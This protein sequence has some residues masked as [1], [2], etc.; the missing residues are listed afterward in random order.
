[1]WAWRMG[2][3][4]SE[5]PQAA[6]RDIRWWRIEAS[7]RRC[8]GVAD[9]PALHEALFCLRADLLDELHVPN[10]AD[11][12]DAVSH[13]LVWAEVEAA[14]KCLVSE[15]DVLAVQTPLGDLALDLAT[16][17]TR[18][19]PRRPSNGDIAHGESE[20]ELPRLAH[21]LHKGFR[22]PLEQTA[23]FLADA[24]YSWRKGNRTCEL[25]KQLVQ[26]LVDEA[27]FATRQLDVDG[28]HV[29]R[30]GRLRPAFEGPDVMAVYSAEAGQEAQKRAQELA[31]QHGHEWGVPF[32]PDTLGN[33][34]ESVV[35][36][37]SVRTLYVKDASAFANFIEQQ[38]VFS[39]VEH[40]GVTVIESGVP[41]RYGFTDPDQERVL[42]DGTRL[43]AA[44]RAHDR[45]TVIESGRSLEYAQEL[46]LRL[47]SEGGSYRTIARSLELEAIPTRKGV[48]AWGSS[49]VMELLRTSAKR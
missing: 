10:L 18:L 19:L 9:R 33:L 40:F 13:A 11:L 43:F 28:G 4:V 24:G 6:P 8:A 25:N 22:L 46:A 3:R 23:A 29:R 38:V 20:D 31:R 30:S 34:L 37:S 16:T 26:R 32:G 49:A 12:G 5:L 47:S 1:M 39:W 27:A 48:G 41:A 17:R 15:D 35:L 2:Y 36:L 21:K 42:R 45:A 14:G 7:S 44:L